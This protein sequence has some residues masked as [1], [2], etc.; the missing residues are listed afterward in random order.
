MT[1]VNPRCRYCGQRRSSPR[2]LR[3]KRM[4]PTADPTLCPLDGHRYPPAPPDCRGC[5]GACIA[6]ESPD[7]QL[8][9]PIC[10]FAG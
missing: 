3:A 6:C 4:S 7:A 9:C 8:P 5:A 2:A 1:N 10:G